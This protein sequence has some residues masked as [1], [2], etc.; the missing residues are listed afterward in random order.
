MLRLTVVGCAELI[1]ISKL[2]AKNSFASLNLCNNV[3]VAL[4]KKCR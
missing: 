4:S 1:S 3:R 2:S